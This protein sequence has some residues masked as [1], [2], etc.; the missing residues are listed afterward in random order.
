MRL[1]INELMGH[2]HTVHKM[3]SMWFMW[4]VTEDKNHKFFVNLEF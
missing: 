1:S 2:Y 4:K 3:H